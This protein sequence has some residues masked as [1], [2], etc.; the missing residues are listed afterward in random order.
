MSLCRHTL[1]GPTRLGSSGTWCRR[2][3]G[4]RSSSR[5]DPQ[6]CRRLCAG[7]V[8]LKR[9]SEAIPRLAIGSAGTMATRASTRLRAVPF[10]RGEAAS[11]RSKHHTS[12]HRPERS[13][14]TH[15]QGPRQQ[16][17]LHRPP[18]GA[19]AEAR[20]ISAR[21]DPSA[22]GKPGARRTLV[23]DRHVAPV[24]HPSHATNASFIPVERGSTAALLRASERLS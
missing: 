7:Q 17:P 6:R 11:G 14:S 19:Q 22:G 21:C 16:L 18:G 2:R 24:A 12:A 10:E 5:D 20:Q 1:T 23:P 3:R 13:R 8:S 9:Y 4:H 15:Q